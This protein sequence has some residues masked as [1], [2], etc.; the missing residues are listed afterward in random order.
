MSEFAGVSYSQRDEHWSHENGNDVQEVS[1]GC[2]HPK[3]K[4]KPAEK[5][6]TLKNNPYIGKWLINI[7]SL[8]K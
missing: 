1:A 7:S 4:T 3:M 2:S 6:R 5:I 8:K